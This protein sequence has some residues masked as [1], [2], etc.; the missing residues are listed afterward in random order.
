M[1]R[2]LARMVAA[3]VREVRIAHSP[4]AAYGRLRSASG[5]SIAGVLADFEL[6]D[7]TG[8]DVIGEARALR[9]ELPAL[10]L[11]GYGSDELANRCAAAR[12][13]YVTKPCTLAAL[14]PFLDRVAPLADPGLSRWERELGAT[15][16]ER[17]VLALVRDGLVQQEVAEVLGIDLST[18]RKHA[19]NLL[20]KA[21]RRGV[22]A[23]SLA[24]L[25][26]ALARAS[27]TPPPDPPEPE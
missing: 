17:R 10:L 9:P 11:T 14:G 5:A 1:A 2:V 22:R 19:S 18:V 15:A 23:S 7:A 24:E 3:R 16:R 26:R 12:V 25:A 27:P 21:R 4:A 8:L 6:G 13:I 20:I